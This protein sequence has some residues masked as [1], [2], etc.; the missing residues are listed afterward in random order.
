[1]T[2]EIW[3]A[4]LI[5]STIVVISPGPVVIMTM[6]LS[7]RHGKYSSLPLIASVVTADTVVMTLSLAGAGAILYSSAQ[8]F[9]I[10]K[11]VGA[12]YM[13]Y[14]AFTMWRSRHHTLAP[15]NLDLPSRMAI[16][17][18]GFLVTVLN[19]KTIFFFCQ[20]PASIY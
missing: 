2:P 6:H 5:A 7:L 15:C 12:L 19:P 11:I 14:L 10:I 1:M 9:N 4:F 18:R 13:L 8:L 16:F 3:F 17:R 20:L